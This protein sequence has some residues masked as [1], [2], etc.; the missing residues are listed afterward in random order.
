MRAKG[1][2]I[3]VRYV[4]RFRDAKGRER[5]YLRMPGAKRVPLPPIDDPGFLAAYQAATAG[6]ARGSGGAPRVAPGSIEALARSYLA[7][8]SFRSMRP[9]TQAAYRRIVAGLV[10][11]RGDRPWALLEARHVRAM[12]DGMADTPAAANHLL[13][14]LR[15]LAGHAIDAGIRGD[16]PTQGVKRL[17]ERGEGAATWTE[18]DIAAYEARWPPGTQQRLALALLLWTGQRR[19]DIVRMGWDDLRGDEIEIVQVKTGAR[20]TIPLA[21]ELAALIPARADRRT[22]LAG[23]TGAYTANGFYMRFKSWVAA[24]GLP[25][26]LSP[27][28]LRKATA[29]R[30]AEGGRTVHQIAAVTGHKTL[31]EVE[32]YTKAADQAR[33]AREAMRGLSNGSGGIVKYTKNADI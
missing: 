18:A 23:R 33:L 17:R 7:S 30:L 5:V 29:R 12:L 20:L 28:G 24:A 27:H 8:A 11:T 14:T 15:A 10:R 3:A 21:P 25:P 9:S 16:D 6:A 22:F 1:I 31:S 32:R 26:G 4:Q 2:R 13:R 19:S